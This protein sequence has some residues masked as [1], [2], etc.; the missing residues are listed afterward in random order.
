MHTSGLRRRWS[1]DQEPGELEAALAKAR[2]TRA[3]LEWI[4]HSRAVEA[5]DFTARET[6]P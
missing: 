1:E 4:Q 6:S 5:Q 2:D 3:L